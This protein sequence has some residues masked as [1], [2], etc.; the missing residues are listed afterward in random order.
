MFLWD[1]GIGGD[2]LITGW[3]RGSRLKVTVKP[4]HGSQVMNLNDPL[5]D[6]LDDPFSLV[7]LEHKTSGQLCW[8]IVSAPGDLDLVFLCEYSDTDDLG[9][10]WTSCLTWKN[11]SINYW[12]LL[13]R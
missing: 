11:P 13:V 12:L 3:R 5:K 8:F 6:P 4:F 9:E 1:K 2:E 7:P 10:K